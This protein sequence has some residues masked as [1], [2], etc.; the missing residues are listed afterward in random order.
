MY[1]AFTFELLPNF[2]R[3]GETGADLFERSRNSLSFY[4]R[5]NGFALRNYIW[6]LELSTKNLFVQKWAEFLDIYLL[7]YSCFSLDFV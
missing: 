5:S 7:K 2:D 6:C 4:F 3:A 1:L